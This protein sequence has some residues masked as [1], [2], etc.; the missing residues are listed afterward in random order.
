MRLR[1]GAGAAPEITC[2]S[3]E[4]FKRE[5][6]KPEQFKPEQFKRELVEPSLSRNNGRLE[7]DVLIVPVN[8]RLYGVPAQLVDA[9]RREE[10][11]EHDC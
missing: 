5:Q 4:Q 11:A 3:F 6:F 2:A 8:V 1:T 9:T 10:S 7:A